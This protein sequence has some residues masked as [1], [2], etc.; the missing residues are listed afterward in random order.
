MTNHGFAFRI[1][2][3]IGRQGVVVGQNTDFCRVLFDDALYAL[4]AVEGI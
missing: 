2:V 1:C 3:G 4:L